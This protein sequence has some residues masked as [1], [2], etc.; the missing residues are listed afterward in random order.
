MT[1]RYPLVI[2][3][4]GRLAELPSGDTVNGVAFVNLTDVPASY[5]GQSLKVVRVNVGESALE[6]A[7]ASAGSPGGTSGQIQYNNSGAFGGFT[8]GGDA[9]LV[10]STGVLTIANSAI[11]TAKINNNAVTYAKIQALSTGPVVLGGAAAGAVGEVAI[12]TGLA[13]VAGV[14]SA[15]AGGS[16]GGAGVDTFNQA[17]IGGL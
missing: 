12:G 6:F 4:N 2:D 3:T 15:T 10:V 11:T 1:A 9:T 14:L 8:L 5:T 7:T 17:F 16:G 13:L